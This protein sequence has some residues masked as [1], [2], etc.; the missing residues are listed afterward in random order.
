[1]NK[2]R[3]KT[4]VPVLRSCVEC[5]LFG[6]LPYEKRTNKHEFVSPFD[7]IRLA[8]LVPSKKGGGCADAPFT[9]CKAQRS[10]DACASLQNMDEGADEQRTGRPTQKPSLQKCCRRDAWWAYHINTWQELAWRC[11]ASCRGAVPPHS[12]TPSPPFSA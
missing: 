9:N 7:L 5:S 12:K 11:V 3:W 8:S 4:Q 1:M 6:N 2:P 10:S